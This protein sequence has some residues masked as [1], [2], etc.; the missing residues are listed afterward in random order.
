ML[1]VP[2]VVDDHRHDVRVQPRR[3]RMSTLLFV[4]VG[5]EQHR[6]A[7]TGDRGQRHM[8][9]QRRTPGDEPAEIR[10]PGLGRDLM[11]PLD[12]MAAFRSIVEPL[13]SDD[14]RL[15]GA[16]Q[17]VCA[18]LVQYCDPN[19]GRALRSREPAVAPSLP[20]LR[21]WGFASGPCSWKRAR[22]PDEARWVKSFDLRIFGSR[23][24]KC[25]S[26]TRTFDLGRP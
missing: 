2:T 12:D 9:A 21:E 26:C 8:E 5:S 13:G 18:G 24:Q 14:V 23:E 19:C 11:R 16:S 22:A 6:I 7:S 15:E 10:V 25:A 20:T 1:H 4:D 3:E 17:A